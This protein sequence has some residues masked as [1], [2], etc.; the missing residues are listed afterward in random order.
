[1]DEDAGEDVENDARDEVRRLHD[2]S[3]RRGVRKAELAMAALDMVENK[4]R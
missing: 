2:A 1:M 4:W 3:W